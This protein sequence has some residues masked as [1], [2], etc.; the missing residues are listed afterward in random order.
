MKKSS[1]RSVQAESCPYYNIKNYET[2]IG[3][4]IKLRKLKIFP[5]LVS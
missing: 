4:V 1:D 2:H 3:R 5:K